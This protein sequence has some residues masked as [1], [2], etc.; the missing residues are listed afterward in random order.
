VGQEGEVVWDLE[1]GF[2]RGKEKQCHF[3]QSMDHL[4][5][6]IRQETENSSSEPTNKC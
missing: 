6:E 5:G 1:E 3:H 2:K 4:I